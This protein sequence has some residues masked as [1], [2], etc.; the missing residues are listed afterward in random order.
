MKQFRIRELGEVGR[1]ELIK[2]LV[3]LHEEGWKSF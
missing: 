3:A 2:D 1:R